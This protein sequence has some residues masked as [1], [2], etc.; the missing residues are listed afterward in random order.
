MTYY[1]CAL[2]LAA[3]AWPLFDLARCQWPHRK[4]NP[5][6]YLAVLIGCGTLV[7]AATSMLACAIALV[8]S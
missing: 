6:D 2:L 4:S 7:F 1:F 8:V 5:D 3:V